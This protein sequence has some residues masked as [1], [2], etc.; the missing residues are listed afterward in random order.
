MVPN[1]T[2]SALTTKLGAVVEMDPRVRVVV[3][4]VEAFAH[5]SDVETGYAIVKKGTPN[6]FANEVAASRDFIGQQT[7]ENSPW[8][9]YKKAGSITS[10][11][12]LISLG[13]ENPGQV[14]KF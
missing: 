7:A 9:W 8:G 5:P 6:E 12:S 1:E 14:I 13:T 11:F 10:E 2:L 3:A 4:A